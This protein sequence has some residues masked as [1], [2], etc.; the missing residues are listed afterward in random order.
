MDNYVHD[1]NNP[2]VPAAGTAAAG[3]VGTGMSISGGRDDTITG[4]TFVNN[5][6]WG[7]ILVPYPDNGGPCTGG[8][9]NIVSGAPC[10]YDEYGDAVLDNTFT[11]NG[12]FGNPTNGDF[13]VTNLEPDPTNCFAGNVDTS[14]KLTSAPSYAETLYPTCNGQT[15]PPTVLNPESALF[16]AEVACDSQISFGNAISVPCL[17]TDHYPRRTQVVMHPLPTRQLPAMPNPCRG[18]PANPWCPASTQGTRTP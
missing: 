1:N 18:V 8:T 16:T 4:N 14:G 10:L 6:A 9:G 2:N 12:R 5:G 3:P 11:N 15:V 17:P 7:V 13:A